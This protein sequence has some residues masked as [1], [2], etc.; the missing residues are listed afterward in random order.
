M[1]ELKTTYFNDLKIAFNERVYEPKEDSFLLANAVEEKDINGKACLDIGTGCGIQAINLA[2]KRAKTVL[3]VDINEEALKII[4]LNARKLGF[5]NIQTRKSNLFENVKE[6]FDLIVFNPPYLPSEKIEE[7]ALDAGLKG[8]KFIDEFLKELKGHLKENGRAFFLQSSLNGEEKTKKKLK[9]L[10]LK[11]KVV[12][13]E[14]FF[15][16]EIMVFLA[17]K[18]STRSAI[19]RGFLREQ[20]S[21]SQ[22]KVM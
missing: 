21:S 16:E 8:R 1:E 5:E 7:K 13:R 18:P 15:F 11:G 17:G 22:D 3:A 12:A 10:G 6:K 14:R 19:F 2:S 9:E 20:K 4:E